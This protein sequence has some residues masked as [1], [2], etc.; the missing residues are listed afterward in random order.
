M[1][2]AIVTPVYPPYRGGI[3]SVAERQARE[4]RARGF[5]VKVFTPDY[6]RE[7][8]PEAT[9]LPSPLKFGNAALLP[10]LLWQLRGID[11]VH[12]H[13]TFYGAEIFVWLW[14]MLR[15]KP[16]AM[17][18]HMQPKAGDWRD[19]FFRLHRFLI[20]PWIVRQASAVF[21]SSLDYAQSIGLHH[22]HL[23]ELPFGVD[24]QRFSPGRDDEYRAKLS[25]PL[26]AMVF[27]FVGG[28][29]EAHAFKGVDILLR[30][31]AQLSRDQDWRVLIV[32]DG[33]LRSFYE[34]LASE[35]GVHD[36]VVFT[37]AITDDDL[38]RAYRAANVH[39]LPS[40]SKSEAFGL[41]TLE[42]AASGLPSIVSDL[43]GVRTLVHPGVTGLRPAPH[44]VKDLATALKTFLFDP[45]LAKKMGMNARQK[46]LNDY[47]EAKLADRL[48]GVYNKITA[49]GQ[50]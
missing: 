17:T 36:R 2:I 34:R 29:D 44:Q 50:V 23:V 20:E 24:T 45:G 25:L 21:V 9:Y 39:V 46:V 28:L 19:I 26:E 32:G 27:I 13:Y 12:V 40:T 5:D 15:R 7:K 33:N 4:L 11:L 16:Y 14:S 31:S 6:G 41:V 18:Y 35:L 30:A 38:P 47:A 48:V 37:G 3:G 22:P 49:H 42:A 10:S 8:N 43:P 1:K